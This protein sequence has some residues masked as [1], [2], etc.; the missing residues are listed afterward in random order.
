V[1]TGR[2]TPQRRLRQA[3]EDAA[4]PGPRRVFR[5]ACRLGAGVRLLVERAGVSI[6]CEDF[7]IGDASGFDLKI[8]AVKLGSFGSSGG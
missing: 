1:R 4:G 8:D 6:S 7:D 3:A 2:T 5:R